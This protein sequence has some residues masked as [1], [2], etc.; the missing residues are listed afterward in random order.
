MILTL[1]LLFDFALQLFLV[2]GFQTNAPT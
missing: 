1:P 2:L